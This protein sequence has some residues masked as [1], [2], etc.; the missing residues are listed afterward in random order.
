LTESKSTSEQIES[1]LRYAKLTEERIN[2]NRI[3]YEPVAIRAS[4]IYLLIIQLSGLDS[5]YQYSL[6]WFISNIII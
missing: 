3:S 1:K 4:H 5:M 2:Q 6:E